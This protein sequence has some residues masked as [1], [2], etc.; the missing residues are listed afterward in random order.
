M[1]SLS[2]DLLFARNMVNEPESRTALMTLGLWHCIWLLRVRLVEARG[3]VCIL[4]TWHKD[5]ITSERIKSEPEVTYVL[6]SL[7]APSPPGEL[8]SSTYLVGHSCI[9]STITDVPE[10]QL[11]KTS[12]ESAPVSR[13]A[14]SFA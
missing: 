10:P 7:E 11:V 2:E 12:M 9:P 13:Y 6:H 8:A 4:G 1:W 14:V 5:T 3:G